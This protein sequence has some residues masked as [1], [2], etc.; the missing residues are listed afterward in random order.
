MRAKW[1]IIIGLL[2]GGLTAGGY[3]LFRQFLKDRQQALGYEDRPAEA[4]TW[5]QERRMPEDRTVR[6]MTP[7]QLEEA[8]RKGTIPQN[9]VP[10]PPQNTTANDAAIQRTLRTIEEINRINEMNRR[11]QEQQQRNK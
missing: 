2:L 3:V 8:R 10:P 6:T 4:R 7:K 9:Y 1:L 11:L 5:D